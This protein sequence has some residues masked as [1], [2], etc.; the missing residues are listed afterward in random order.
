MTS[1]CLLPSFRRRYIKYPQTVTEIERAF[2]R[3]LPGP[4]G[5]SPKR[6]VL[7]LALDQESRS[8]LAQKLTN[9]FN[10]ACQSCVIVEEFFVGNMRKSIHANGVTDDAVVEQIQRVAERL[11]DYFDGGDD[12]HASVSPLPAPMACW[13]RS[14]TLNLRTLRRAQSSF[15]AS[16]RMR[17][18]PDAVRAA[19]ELAKEL[20]GR[21]MVPKRWADGWRGTNKPIAEISNRPVFVRTILDKSQSSANDAASRLSSE[22]NVAF[23]Y[24]F[25]DESENVRPL[26]QLPESAVAS[27]RSGLG[28]AGGRT[29][30]LFEYRSARGIRALAGEASRPKP[31]KAALSS[32]TKIRRPRAI[33]TIRSAAGS[34]GR[35]PA[36]RDD[37]RR[38]AAATRF[39]SFWLRPADR[40]DQFG[41]QGHV[42]GDCGSRSSHAA[43][44]ERSHD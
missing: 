11:R 14:Q 34:R 38:A 37:Q 21:N 4:D 10:A 20:A 30:A 18:V 8:W 42:D 9:G 29:V 28:A 7:A 33:W 2:S 36:L 12:G 3:L 5:R 26:M 31:G 35:L 41:R 13:M 19:D 6:R 15:S 23:G 40:R 32:T 1:L 44:I 22:L 24:Q 25:D 27:R 39:C 16:R 43:R 17:R